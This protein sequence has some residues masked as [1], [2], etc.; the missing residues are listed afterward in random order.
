MMIGT[1][2]LYAMGRDGLLW[3]RAAQVNTGGTPGIATI[4][5]TLVA[6]GLLTVGLLGHAV[7]RAV[8]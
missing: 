4:V 2:I 6:T 7:H 3:S 5:T 8:R 1:R